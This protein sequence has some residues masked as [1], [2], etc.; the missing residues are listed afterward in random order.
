MEGIAAE[1]ALQADLRHLHKQRMKMA[2]KAHLSKPPVQVV[3]LGDEVEW[4][5]WRI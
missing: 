2:D 5:I 1:I 3:A 4:M